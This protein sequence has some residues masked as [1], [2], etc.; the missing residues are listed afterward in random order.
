MPTVYDGGGSASRSPTVRPDPR[1]QAL[2][3]TARLAVRVRAKEHQPVVAD[4][5]G[6]LLEV[7]RSRPT[8]VVC[9]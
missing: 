8:M 3:V 4:A 2:G 6:E 5:D 1:H 9:W 7:M